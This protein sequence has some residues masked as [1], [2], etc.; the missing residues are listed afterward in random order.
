V[1]RKL[2]ER[3]ECL[4]RER[5]SKMQRQ[6][7]AR[8][9]QVLFQRVRQRSR[10]KWAAEISDP[11]E[12]TLKWLHTFSRAYDQAAFTLFV[13]RAQLNIQP[14]SSRPP[15]SS[16]Q[17]DLTGLLPRSTAL[18]ICPDHHLQVHHG[19]LVSG[20]PPCATPKFNGIRDQNLQPAPPP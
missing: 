11:R 13:S 12:R 1:R 3:R 20:Y 18:D 2:M 17:T 4:A 19:S 15:V 16:H 7:L 8:Q 5:K 6:R 14:P 9:Q 10:E